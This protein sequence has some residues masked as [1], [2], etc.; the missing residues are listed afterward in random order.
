MV[1]SV[2]SRIFVGESHCRNEE[3]LQVVSA[4]LNEVVATAKALRPYHPFLR[5]LLRPFLAPKSRMRGVINKA[6]QVLLPAIRDRQG[7][8]AEHLDLLQFLVDTSP[9][10]KI[11]PLV[12]KLLVLT[13]AAVSTDRL[14]YTNHRLTVL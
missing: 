9:D 14:L 4:Y 10:G 6:E 11:R 13:S 2:S 12:L 5:P 7:S 3:W 1:L 8:H